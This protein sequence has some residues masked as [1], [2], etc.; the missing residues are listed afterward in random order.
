MSVYKTG[1]QGKAAV[2][3]EFGGRKLVARVVAR[4]ALDAAIMNNEVS[5]IVKIGPLDGN[6]VQNKRFENASN[7]A[8]RRHTAALARIL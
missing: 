1:K 4:Q 7:I 8:M 3:V 6:G 2:V 5:G